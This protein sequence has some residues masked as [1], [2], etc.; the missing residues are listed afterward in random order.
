MREFLKKYEDVD[1]RT[2][3]FIESKCDNVVQEERAYHFDVPIKHRKEWND[4]SKEKDRIDNALREYPRSLFIHLISVYD[5]FFSKMIKCYLTSVQGSIMV[6]GADKSVS[7]QE[8]MGCSSLDELKNKIIEQEIDNLMRGSHKAQLDW[9]FSKV[10]G[11]NEI[12]EDLVKSF[13]EMAERRN[14]FVHTDGVVSKQYIN[15]CKQNKI[16]LDEDVK[17]GRLILLLPD[18][19]NDSIN[20]LFELSSVLTIYLVKSLYKDCD[21]VDHVIAEHIFIC[22]QDKNYKCVQ[23]LSTYLKKWKLN[24]AIQMM[25]DVNYILTFY[26]QGDDKTTNEFVSQIDWSNCSEEFKLAKA[27]LEKKWKEASSIMMK[28]GNNPKEEKQD[29]Y[30]SWPLFEKFRMTTEFAK[31]YRVLFGE[32]FSSESTF[33]G[34]DIAEKNEKPKVKVKT[35][36]E[37]KSKTGTKSKAK[38]GSKSKSKTGTKSKAKAGNRSRAKARVRSKV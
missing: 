20:I 9:L 10:K 4:L 28:C 16:K 23:N 19:F 7:Y 14:L 1:R 32:S 5:H 33:K 6:C 36:V 27:V 3:F 8:I 21:Y 22:L 34:P 31:T 2:R 37:L 24:N 15:V 29:A 38:V 11:P 13:I 12:N 25:V 30:I 17:I 35:D 26:L 18:Y